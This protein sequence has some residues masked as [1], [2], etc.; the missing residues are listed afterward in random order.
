MPVSLIPYLYNICRLYRVQELDVIKILLALAFFIHASRSDWKTRRVNDVVWIAL[1]SIAFIVLIIE[2]MIRDATLLESTLLLPL[3]FIFYDIFWDR[4]HG[5]RTRTGA[6]ALFLYTLSFVWVI[7]VV[8]SSPISSYGLYVPPNMVALVMIFV[9]IIMFELFYILDVIKGGADAKAIICLAILFPWYPEI[10]DSLPL[11]SPSIESMRTYFPFA[12]SALFVAALMSLF[13]P[14]YFLFKNISA[15]NKISL[16]SFVGFTIPIAE[17]DKRFVWLMEWV[18]GGK[19]E[20]SA[21]KF[22]SSETLSADLAALQA[23]GLK[24]VWVTF[25]IPFIIPMTVA[26]LFVLIIGNPL[27]ALY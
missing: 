2:L 27:F 17:V 14:L 16:R 26:V 3:A 18:E 13:I 21:R 22:R 8:A 24:E 19:L 10:A 9:L 12:L 4:E 11:I 23:L 25:K 1:G 6:L 7:L 15:G 20:F 5:W